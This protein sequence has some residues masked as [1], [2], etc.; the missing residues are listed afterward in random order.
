MKLRLFLPVWL[1]SA[2]IVGLMQPQ[3]VAQ[4]TNLATRSVQAIP[5]PLVIVP[6]LPPL[7]PLLPESDVT[8]RLVLKRSERRV[9]VYRGSQ[10]V[11]SYPVAVGRAGWETPMGS[12]HV[13]DM[14][15]QPTWVH[16]FTGEIMTA[17]PENPLGERWIGFWTNGRSYIGF[18]G[19]PTRESVGRAASHGC[20]R[21][22]NEDVRELYKI[23]KLGTPVTV[24]P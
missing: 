16:P 14:Q 24:E 23:V 22:Y 9:Y 10:Q 11:A 15:E 5:M 20:V 6:E 13:I 3:M 4:T 8:I 1:G 12:W 17:G 19:T 7:K 18:H 2:L 21:M